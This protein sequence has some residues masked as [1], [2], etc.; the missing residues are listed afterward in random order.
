[1][2]RQSSNNNRR[3]RWRWLLRWKNALNH[4]YKNNN[5]RNF[6]FTKFSFIDFVLT[7]GRS[8]S[9]KRPKSA[10][11]K[12]SSCRFSSQPWEMLTPKPLNTQFSDFLLVYWFSSPSRKVWTSLSVSD[13]DFF[14]L[15]LRIVKTLPFIHQPDWEAPK[16]SDALAADWLYQDTWKN[17]TFFHVCCFNYIVL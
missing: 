4:D 13:S 1:M 9:H 3:V 11:G 5:G 7:D 12:S 10:S 2:N 14:Q 17:T 15:V 16:A 8:L 6:Q